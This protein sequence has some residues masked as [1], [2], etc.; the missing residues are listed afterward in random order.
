MIQADAGILQSPCINSDL[1]SDSYRLNNIY[2]NHPASM[3]SPHAS[4]FICLPFSDHV[5]VVTAHTVYFSICIC[6]ALVG[7]V[8]AVLFLTQLIRS[9]AN[10]NSSLGGS[11][12]QR[13]ILIM[14][15]ISDLLAD[16]GKSVRN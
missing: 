8:G 2:S 15:A 3:A 5:D 7:G 4:S 14:L 6:S 16:V 1:K 9:N 12:S 13:S 10:G 11:S